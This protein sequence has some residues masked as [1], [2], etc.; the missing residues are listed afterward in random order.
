MCLRKK[1]GCEIKLAEMEQVGKNMNLIF[2]FYL[3]AIKAIG[4]DVVDTVIIRFVS[5]KSLFEI[6]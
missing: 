5:F 4:S 3:Y 6:R 2:V 1:S